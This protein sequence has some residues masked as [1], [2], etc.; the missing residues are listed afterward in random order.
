[1]ITLSQFAGSTEPVQLQV[2]AQEN[3]AAYNPTGDPV[4]VAIL[5]DTEDEPSPSS[6]AWN[7]AEWETD[8]GNPPSY[9]ASLMVGPTGA[10]TLTAGSYIA[11]VKVTD[12]VSG[13][14][15]IKAGAYLIII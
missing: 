6:D 7:G 12:S 8:P 13:A 14:T 15:P 4:A 3:G 9:W 10:I 1:M 5:P 2:E 11:Y